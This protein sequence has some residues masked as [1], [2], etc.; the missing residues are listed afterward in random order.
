M[1][2]SANLSI[3]S[4]PDRGKNFLLDGEMVHLGRAAENAILL[5]DPLV[6][7]HHAS[8]VSR[9]GRFA[10][11]TTVAEGIEVDGNPIPTEK[12]VWLP[13]S[14]A[15]QLS[16]RTAAQFTLGNNDSGPQERAAES[17]DSAEQ[18][19]PRPASATASV[20]TSATVAAVSPTV[21]S[22]TPKPGPSSSP[23]IPSLRSVPKAK[24]PAGDNSES[25]SAEIPRKGKGD[26]QT[27]K[28]SKVARFITDGPGDPL[29][30][31]GEDGH[32]PD[33]AL[34]EGK[35]M[36]RDAQGGANKSSST[37]LLTVALLVS[38]LASVA[39][40]FVDSGPDAN[41]QDKAVARQQIAAFYSDVKGTLE[42]Y[43]VSLRLAQQAHSR[44]NRAAE[45]RE[46]RKVLEL[47]RSE[48]TRRLITGLTGTRDKDAELERLISTL[49][50]G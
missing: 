27:G 22:P 5:T 9:N 2:A 21:E 33:L 49:I 35:H 14:A 18:P 7:E 36:K 20:A 12:W 46:Y 11:Y 45:V 38:S 16:K 13:E 34:A 42:P 15:I 40:L 23:S 17:A 10:I 1:T 4:G 43:Q 24:K 28:K 37:W 29:V 48:S 50:S 8:F 39:L 30:R 3:S 41:P 31:L 19:T 6:S 44:G 32:L 25:S 26:T 47:L